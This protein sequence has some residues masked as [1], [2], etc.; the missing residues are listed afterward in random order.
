M[1]IKKPQRIIIVCHWMRTQ[2]FKC[3]DKFRNRER[4]MR[5]VNECQKRVKVH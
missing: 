2:S 1:T 4:G 3:V 5:V